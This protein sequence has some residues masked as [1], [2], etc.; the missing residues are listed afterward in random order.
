MYEIFRWD[1]LPVV[2]HPGPPWAIIKTEAKCPCCRRGLFCAPPVH[3]K[4]SFR[5]PDVSQ[6]KRSLLDCALLR[7]RDSVGKINCENLPHSLFA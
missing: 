3:A 5:R 7:F 4:A 2:A 6:K 1:L